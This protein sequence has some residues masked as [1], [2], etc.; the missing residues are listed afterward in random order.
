M[1]C[2]VPLKVHSACALGDGLGRGDKPYGR[3]AAWETQGLAPAASSGCGM[4]GHGHSFSII[5]K[6]PACA[7]ESGCQ[8]MLVCG[9]S[10]GL[11]VL[12]RMAVGTE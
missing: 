7:L 11:Q 6:R 9:A 2:P 8:D 3:P 4:D 5:R 10:E 1:A 12:G